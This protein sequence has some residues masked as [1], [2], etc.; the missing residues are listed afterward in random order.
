[1]KLLF[2]APLSGFP[3]DPTAL[4]VQAS[5][6]HLAKKLVFAAPASGL[7]SLPTALLLQL[8]CASAVPIESAAINTASATLLISASPLRWSERQ[9][10]GP[11]RLSPGRF[12]RAHLE[13]VGGHRKPQFE[14]AC[15]TTSPGS[16]FV[17]AGRVGPFP[18]AQAPCDDLGPLHG[19]L[20]HSGVFH[21]LAT[22]ALALF[23]QPF[24]Q[25]LK[26]ADEPVDVLD[27]VRRYALNQR[28]DIV[29]HHLAV[30]LRGLP[31]A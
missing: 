24:A 4:G 7:P 6:L 16:S 3:F 13:F 11:P 22:H 14:F 20:A 29:R 15:I 21:D 9:N 18:M 17:D 8:S 26:V 23:M 28:A 5:R 1:M 2:A 31:Q 10:K 19:R 25:Y 30:V 12:V 27:R